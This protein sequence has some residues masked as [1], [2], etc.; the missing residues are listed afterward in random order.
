MWMWKLLI[1]GLGH[2]M[3]LGHTI[4]EINFRFQPK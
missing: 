1:L 3:G 4:F 2:P